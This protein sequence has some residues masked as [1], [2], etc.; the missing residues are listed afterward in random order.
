MPPTIWLVRRWSHLWIS[1]TVQWIIWTWWQSITPG[2]IRLHIQGKCNKAM[3]QATARTD[4]HSLFRNEISLWRE[5]CSLWSNR[6]PSTLFQLANFPCFWNA[7]SS[8][9]IKEKVVGA[10][11]TVFFPHFRFSFCQYPFILSIAAKRTILQRDSEQQMIIMA[12]VSG[13]KWRDSVLVVPALCAEKRHHLKE[14]VR[15]PPPAFGSRPVCLW[16]GRNAS[17]SGESLAQKI[18]F[19]SWAVYCLNCREVSWRRYSEDSCPTSACCSWIWLYDAPISFP[20]LSTRSG[21]AFNF[22]WVLPWPCIAIL[23]CI[24]LRRDTTCNSQSDYLGGT[25]TARLEE[26]AEGNVFRRTRARHGRPHQG[27]VL[28]S[29]QTNLQTRLR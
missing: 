15:F 14:V 22:T 4:I 18:G 26:E 12:R 28:A 6:G 1:T 5:E 21:I 17:R 24:R 20:T 23:T 3:S 25:Q 29:H 11:T 2:K 9:G 19:S 7:Q 27:V 16:S 8:V 13:A 10:Q